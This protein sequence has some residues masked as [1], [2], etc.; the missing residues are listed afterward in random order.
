MLTLTILKY[1][2]YITLDLFKIIVKKVLET[3]KKII[4]NLLSISI[5]SRNL[6]KYV[7]KNI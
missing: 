3:L 5:I 7:D 2:F 1:F 4:Q 6:F